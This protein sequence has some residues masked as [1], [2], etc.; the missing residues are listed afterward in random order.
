MDLVIRGGTVFDGTL[1]DG[2]EMDIAI[3]D[4]VIAQMGKVTGKGAEEIDARG[5]IVTPGFVDI[6]THYDAQ[7]IWSQRLSPSSSHGVTTAVIGNCGVGFAP[8]RPEHRELMIA[9]C[10]GVEDIPGAVMAEGLTWDWETYPQ[11]LD[12]LERRRRDI[13]LA[14]LFPHMPMRVY[15]MGER[16]ANREPATAEDL[17]NMYALTREAISA[18]ALGLAT[19]MLFT[20][21]TRDGDLVPT[22][23]CAEEELQTLARA[24]RDAGGGVLQTPLSQLPGG[25]PR[26]SSPSSTGFPGPWAAGRCS[27]WGRWRRTPGSGAGRWTSPPGSTRPAARCARRSSRAASA[28]CSAST[29]PSIRSR[30][31]RATWPSP[32]F[33]WPRRWRA[34]AIRLSA[35][36]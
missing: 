22:F 31:A 17:A 36:S 18:G 25:T 2:R 34:C 5:R 10:E 20:H 21:R 29:L 30:C 11:Y 32:T 7:A 24:V 4:G 8:C 12:A 1:A 28:C 15:A 33:P 9:V 19:S 13:N 35:P 6:H 14:S 26:R 16:G 23:G 27:P 3:E